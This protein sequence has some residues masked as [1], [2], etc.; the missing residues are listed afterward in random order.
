MLTQKT[1][2]QQIVPELG[3]DPIQELNDILKDPL[4]EGQSK[5]D[6]KK[7]VDSE[8][9]GSQMLLDMQRDRRKLIEQRYKKRTEEE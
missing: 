5:K 8:T 6:E 2:L 4:S 9:S 7:Q 3:R 1:Q